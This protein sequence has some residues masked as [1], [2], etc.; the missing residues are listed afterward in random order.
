M[1]ETKSKNI[2][3]RCT[4]TERK[5]VE[6]FAKKNNTTVSN[7]VL[8]S[9]IAYIQAEEKTSTLSPTFAEQVQY[10]IFR[11]KLINLLNINPS[12]PEETK[13]YLYKELMKI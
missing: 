7:L 12:I 1:K 6:D 5:R 3:G 10:N 9:V 13:E 11:N 2:K 8:S 4:P